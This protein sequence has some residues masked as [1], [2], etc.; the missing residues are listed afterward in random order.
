MDELQEIHLPLAR[1]EIDATIVVDAAGLAGDL[2]EL[3]I[4]VEGVFLEPRDIGI[5]V[6]R[7]DAAADT[8][9]SPRSARSSPGARRPTNDLGEVVEHRASDHL[10]PDHHRA[11]L[12]LILVLSRHY[13]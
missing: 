12:I 13:G 10:L 5:G 8:R 2:L 9:S 4:Q 7:G 6:E 3:A 1:G 11:P